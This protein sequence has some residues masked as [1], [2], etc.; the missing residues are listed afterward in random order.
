MF[1]IIDCAS[2]NVIMGSKLMFKSNTRV[3]TND[4][5]QLFLNGF[6]SEALKGL[7]Y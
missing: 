5:R 6:A 3:N 2:F 7:I 1:Q 4:H